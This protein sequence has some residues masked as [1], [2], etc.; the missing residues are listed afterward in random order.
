MV[1]TDI[2]KGNGQNSSDNG[3]ATIPS[4]L[5][6]DTSKT[7]QKASAN[8]KYLQKRANITGFRKLINVIFLAS[9]YDWIFNKVKLSTIIVISSVM[10]LAAAT[11]WGSQI[12]Y[13]RVSRYIEV[14]HF[15]ESYTII[16]KASQLR[17]AMA[18]ERNL[19]LA[20]LLQ[21]GKISAQEI[22]NISNERQNISDLMLID[23][24]NLLE[25][26]I[27]SESFAQ[28]LTTAIQ[29]L[30]DSL[31]TIALYEDSEDIYDF[32]EY[33][34]AYNVATES[35]QKL[36]SVFYIHAKVEEVGRALLA[37][38]AFL[39][40][41][42]WVNREHIYLYSYGSGTSFDDEFGIEV[43]QIA[44]REE[45]AEQEFFAFSDIDAIEEFRQNVEKVLQTHPTNRIL[46]EV[47]YSDNYEVEDIEVW[48]RQS[49][50]R[51]N[52]VNSFYDLYI[53][54]NIDEVG[55]A[56]Y[57]EAL[58]SR[59][60]NAIIVAIVL[61]S[62]FGSMLHTTRYLISAFRR[63]ALI[64]SELT[65]GRLDVY[66]PKPTRNEV[67]EMFSA[68]Q[69]LKENAI[70][71][72]KLHQ[73]QQ[74]QATRREKRAEAMEHLISEFDVTVGQVLQT[75]DD[76]SETLRRTSDI[77][78][79]SVTSTTETADA[80]VEKS[81]KTTED[82]HQVVTAAGNLA[83]SVQQMSEQFRLSAEV[84]HRSA[85]RAEKVDEV[86][87][88]LEESTNQISDVLGIIKDIAEQINLL[89]LN[90]TIE[91]ARAGDA[92]KGFAVVAGEVKNLATQTSQSTDKIDG[93]IQDVQ[94][95]TREVLNILHGLKGAIDEVETNSSNIAQSSEHQAITTVQISD[96]MRNAARSV[97][98]IG[99]DITVVQE[100]AKAARKI[101]TEVTDAVSGLAEQSTTLSHAVNKFL[102]EIRNT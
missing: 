30:G 51:L 52:I 64:M 32:L 17:V 57:Q 93:L 77:M 94:V 79:Q 98:D 60:L 81:T 89:A 18:K 38:D 96:N 102:H 43:N 82:V 8:Q 49:E 39:T 27:L 22:E 70:E 26:E 9:M 90:A 46:Q 37:T 1:D 80:A 73:Q 61:F 41:Y 55:Q 91:A 95:I 47:L 88:S 83:N 11:F 28:D 19:V 99:T 13:E 84:A 74:D 58:F 48:Y 44:I 67:G 76:A 2:T 7:Q 14:G 63:I 10:P 29:V 21:P 16:D 87:N 24:Y 6:V 15:V 56:S 71:R 3:I 85:E 72:E 4:Q 92:G 62:V 12:L 31:A 33:Y 75:I 50:D 45:L 20:N 69:I 5:D 68:L 36:F 54:N 35:L 78:N 42:D 65:Q 86:S 66:V 34:G 101:F 97:E 59:N 23:Y 40:Y 100:N 25:T 53:K